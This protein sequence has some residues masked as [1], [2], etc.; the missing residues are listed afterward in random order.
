[1][2]NTNEKEYRVHIT[3]GSYTEKPSRQEVEDIQN[4]ISHSAI[5]ATKEMIAKYLVNGYSV[6]TGVLEPGVRNKNENVKYNEVLMLDFDNDPKNPDGSTNTALVDPD[7]IEH[8]LA[9]KWVQENV[10][11]LYETFSS[12]PD[13]PRFRAVVFPAEPVAAK[14]VKATFAFMHDRLEE[15]DVSL[16]KAATNPARLF[17]GSQAGKHIVVNMDNEWVARQNEL[18]KRAPK[19]NT[20]AMGSAPIE[21]DE[22]LAIMEAFAEVNEDDLSERSGYLDAMITLYGNYTEDQLTEDQ[23]MEYAAALAGDNDAWANG[24][25]AHM[26]RFINGQDSIDGKEFLSFRDKFQKTVAMKDK[27]SEIAEDYQRR[28]NPFD[29]TDK[30]LVELQKELRTKKLETTVD[31]QEVAKQPESPDGSTTTKYADGLVSVTRNKSGE[32]VHVSSV[33]DS[34]TKIKRHDE[35]AEI[36]A[37]VTKANLTLGKMY[38]RPPELG[39]WGTGDDLI[40]RLIDQT[41]GTMNRHNLGEVK[42]ILRRKAT[43]YSIFS[44]RVQLRNGY[45]LLDGDVVEGWTDEYT[46]YYFDVDYDPNAYSKDVDELLNGIA[47]ND[48]EMRQYIEGII[49]HLLLRN[50]KEQLMIFFS[51]GNKGTKGHGGTGKSTLG[52]MLRNFVNGVSHNATSEQKNSNVGKPQMGASIPVEKFSDN[53]TAASLVSQAL[54]FGDETGMGYLKD[55]SMIKSLASGGVITLRVAYGADTMNVESSA[56]LI[57]ATNRMPDMEDDSDGM[58]QRVHV[59]DFNGKVY[60]GTDDDDKSLESKLSTR[61]AQS[62]ILNLGLKGVQYMKD[63]GRRLIKPERVRLITESYFSASDAVAQFVKEKDEDSEVNGTPSSI[64]GRDH[65]IVFT[66]FNDWCVAVGYAKRSRKT[67]EARMATLGYELERSSRKIPMYGG[68]EGKPNIFVRDTDAKDK[69]DLFNDYTTKNDITNR[70]WVDVYDEYVD[71][72]EE[73]HIAP[74][75][76]K[77]FN[78]RVLELGY[79][80]KKSATLITNND[81]TEGRHM[82]YVKDTELEKRRAQAA[83]LSDVND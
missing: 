67:F 63:N 51:G 31:L 37:E 55:T 75:K 58:M 47:K 43:E 8:V 21:Y 42:S 68:K 3:S 69:Y 29:M 9:N 36:V 80:K 17:H 76:R 19:A 32:I 4:G 26:E 15:F 46:P 59:I 66:D 65:Q 28:I 40:K 6:T 34:A 24:N 44:D 81:G 78:D 49:G 54:N 50:R 82:V 39:Y 20:P 64:L 83:L 60:R 1:M 79:E 70:Y 56:T 53:T 73:E 16:D 77:A 22:G 38:V 72:A 57:F 35:L 5:N 48:P 52:D 33:I 13:A 74:L 71:L 27:D 11:F 10:A 45:H 25:V 18:P 12:T 14:D 41:I 23:A 62:Y 7:L 30:E 61:E 2:T